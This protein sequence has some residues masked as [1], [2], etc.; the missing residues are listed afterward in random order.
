MRNFIVKRVLSIIP[1]LIIVSVVIFSV[2]H[3]TPGDPAASILGDE[4]T[5]E[6]IAALRERMGLD[7]PVVEQ[8]F[9]WMGNILHGDFGMSVAG[10]ETVA[11]LL[12]SHWEPTISLALFSTVIA[13]G[14]AIPLGILA[15]RNKGT[16][17]DSGIS[18]LSLMGI[19]FP[20]FL[21]G[22]F[23][24]MVFAVKLKLLPVSG[25]KTLSDGFVPHIRSLV[26]PGIALGFMHS[27]LLMRMTKASM[28][29]V[30][31]SDYVKMAKAKGV[32]EFL[33][34]AKHAFRNALIP[35]ITTVGQ[36]IVGALAGAAVVESMFAIPGMGQLMV[37]SI[38]RRD[39]YVIQAIVLIIACI[40]V[41]VNLLVDLLYG[42]ADPRVRLS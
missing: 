31:N 39:Y 26:L 42:I 14:I 30:L 3:L 7:K 18:A 28:L 36:S 27:A 23:L 33:L 22:L 8:Y 4:A 17:I 20:S 13:L 32:K 35:V 11:N 6:D 1:V 12:K 19:S 40:N 37:N 24:M 41:L 38:G 5:A 25:Y 21:L 9:V 2:V 34:V 29:E 16:A 10:N 15:A